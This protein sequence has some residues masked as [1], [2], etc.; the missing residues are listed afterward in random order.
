MGKI[1]PMDFKLFRQR[2]INMILSTDMARS[3]EDLDALNDLIE[4]S[5][6]T[7]DK[8]FDCLIDK[9]S[10]TTEFKSQQ[11]FLD[12]VIHAGDMSV[13]L[14]PFETVQMWTYLLFDEFFT[15][16]DLEKAQNLTVSFLCDREATNVRN[17]QPFFVTNIVMP[18][19]STI[20]GIF[21]SMESTTK[22]CQETVEKWQAHVETE[23]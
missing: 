20:A 10:K 1:S 12:T 4:H 17:M 19:F 11:T 5:G 22:L 6:F 2:F 16:G 8:N 9:T 13:A 23:E 18:L 21:P 15:Q 14:R 3:K 7:A